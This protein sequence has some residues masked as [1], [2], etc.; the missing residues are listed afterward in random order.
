MSNFNP[1]RV[2]LV[3]QVGSNLLVRG[4][5]PIVQKEGRQFMAFDL[6]VRTIN[7]CLESGATD[8]HQQMPVSTQLPERFHFVSLSL[9]SNT[10]LEGRYLDMETVFFEQHPDKG[11]VIHDDI[12]KVINLG[13]IKE[14]L[15]K[16]VEHRVIQRLHQLLNSQ[17]PDPVVVYLHS[18]AGLDRTGAVVYSYAMR[19][20][21]YAFQDAIRLNEQSGFRQI[22]NFSLMAVEQYAYYLKRFMGI[23][24]VGEAEPVEYNDLAGLSL[25]EHS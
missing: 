7:Q 16:Q 4:N 3:D 5:T 14:N 8:I 1:T 24:T 18:A 15:G 13:L 25:V 9:M 10:G 6:V 22:N 2:R 21:S 19:H 23:S 20:A 11:L 17:L 12:E